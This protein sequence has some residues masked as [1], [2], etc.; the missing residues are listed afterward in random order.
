MQSRSH[1][2]THLLWNGIDVRGVGGAKCKYR[3]GRLLPKIVA[4]N[5]IA[6]AGFMPKD[7]VSPADEKPFWTKKSENA[8]TDVGNNL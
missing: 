4:N 5:D 8:E 2:V 3:G 1:V 7:N 6:F